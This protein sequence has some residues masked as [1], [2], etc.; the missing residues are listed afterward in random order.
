MKTKLIKLK[1]INASHKG[2]VL[3]YGHFT[4][5]HAGHIRYLK[6]AKSKGKKLIIS[7]LGDNS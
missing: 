7:L 5:I 6:Y 1:D 3:T 2:F 4:T